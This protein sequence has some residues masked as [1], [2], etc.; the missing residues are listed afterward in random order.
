MSRLQSNRF[1][2]FTCPARNAPW[3]TS[4]STTLLCGTLIAV[5]SVSAAERDVAE[6]PEPV[7]AGIVLD[8]RV[9]AMPGLPHGPFVHLDGDRILGV[10]KKDAIMSSDGGK[11][12]ERHP[13]FSAEQPYEI[14]DERALLR[15]RDGSIVLLFMNEAVRHYSWDK[16]KNLPKPDMLLPSYAIRSTDNGQTWTD[17]NELHGGWC[18]CLQD[19]IQ[20]KGGNLV[21]PGQELLY[22]E[23]RHATMPYVSKDD[24]QT[25]LRTRY[26]DFGG[27]GDHAGAIEGTLEQ[28]RDGRLW[29]LIRSYHGYFYESYSED[30]GLTWTDIA[31]SRILSTGSPGKLV[32]LA[33][34]RLALFWNA[35]PNDGFVRRE[36]LS[37]AFSED[38]GLTWSPAQVIATNK[39]GRVSYVQ[40]FEYR[41][42]ELWVTTM[43][44]DVRIRLRESDFL[45]DWTR[46]VAFGDSTTA[47][48]GKVVVYVDRLEHGL[49]ELGIDAAIAN[50]GV[51]GNT[52]EDGRTRFQAEVLDWK[53]ALVIIQFG[54]ND[55]AVDVWQNPPATAPR[56]SRS[57]YKENLTYFL[58]ELESRGIEAILMTPNP[59]RWAEKTREL[60]NKSPYNI[61]EPDGFNVLL[62]E[63]AE[64]VREVA[65]DS[66]TP[67]VDVYTAF[68]DYGAEGGQSM[69]DLLLDG[70]HPN[71]KGHALVTAILSGALRKTLASDTNKS[72]QN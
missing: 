33:S 5:F 57:R 64:A 26:L 28:M 71:D 59:M 36:Q 44:G 17:L 69:D 50:A 34:G 66:G 19:I 41:P 51:P 27:Q 31:P 45:K 54:I 53:P 68:Q 13:I 63:Y 60:Y 21:V 70:M 38:D 40:V 23:G 22:E 58:R 56:V 7:N 46:L 42:G 47:P 18:G 32:R 2:E 30:E 35:P 12:W 29:M 67:L 9:E 48:R 10:D 6:V 1:P 16:E 55:S 61:D 62:K 8:P 20:T 72:A 65:Q 25:W 39:G 15:T 52:T 14:R 49:A 24:G 11:T 3:R 4:F 43:Q 37:L